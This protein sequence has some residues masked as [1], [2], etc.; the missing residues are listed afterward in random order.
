MTVVSR[1]LRVIAFLTTVALL[2]IVGYC[3]HTKTPPNDQWFRENYETNK[4][5]FSELINLVCTVPNLKSA[6]G[7]GTTNDG[8]I[9]D[10]QTLSKIVSLMKAIGTSHVQI[11][12]QCS[13]WAEV[14]SIGF[15]GD[16]VYKKYGYNERVHDRLLVTSI[17]D[18]DKVRGTITTPTFYELEL[19]DGWSILDDVWP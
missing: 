16:G 12:G 7:D 5:S 1:I 18:L 6:R 10:N 11:T 4:A 13:I 14:W 3:Q 2:A 9:V 17:D 19:N 8:P 15:G